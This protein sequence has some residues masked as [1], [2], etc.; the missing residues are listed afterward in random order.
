MMDFKHSW[1]IEKLAIHAEVRIKEFKSRWG[2]FTTYGDLE[3]N[4]L[5]VLALAPNCI[6]DYVVVHELCHLL[7]HYHSPQF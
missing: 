6:V 3:F 2:S 5:I 1:I 7:H 4:W